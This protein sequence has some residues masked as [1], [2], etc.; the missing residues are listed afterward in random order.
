MDLGITGRT[1]LVTGAGG[2]L[3]SAISLALAREGAHV[4]GAD[5]SAGALQTLDAAMR[6]ENLRFDAVPFDLADP[7][8]LRAGIDQVRDKAGSPDILV[9]NTGGPPP[10]AVTELSAENWQT[11]FEAMVTPVIT[12][13]DLLLP[14]MRAAGWGRIITS[15]S[16]GVITPIPNLGLSNS[17]RSALVGWSKTL[18]GEIAGD[19]VTANVVVPGRIATPRIAAL[20]KARAQR[21]GITVE[22]AA[23]A[24]TVGI[25]VGRYGRPEEYASLV[26]YLAG[27][28]A[29]FITGSIIRCDGGMIPSI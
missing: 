20:D 15:A 2:G 13:T 28:P 18:A 17:L 19:G 26:T 29:S 4:I 16:S 3:G 10:L 22:E 8:A 12:M 24:S 27:D 23:R 1:A 9:N 6:A 7:Q 11:W 21:E 14:A 5:I 25:P